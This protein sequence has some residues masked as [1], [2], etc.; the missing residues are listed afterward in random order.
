MS[1][2][3]GVECDSR[4]MVVMMIVMVKVVKVNIT[5]LENNPQNSF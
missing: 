4:A 5:T 3:S 2:M 1:E